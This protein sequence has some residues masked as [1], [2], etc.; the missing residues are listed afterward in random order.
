MKKIVS[1][2]KEGQRNT[3]KQKRKGGKVKAAF[4]VS[5]SKLFV[6]NLKAPSALGA[7]TS[8]NQKTY[9][10]YYKKCQTMRDG[11]D[12]LRLMGISH[13]ADNIKK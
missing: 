11:G 4:W 12:N 6:T 2:L 1:Y 3:K 7:V 9:K 8:L 5:S 10:V 13:Q